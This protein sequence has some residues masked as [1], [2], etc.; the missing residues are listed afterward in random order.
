MSAAFKIRKG[1]SV[2]EWLERLP[3]KQSATLAELRSLIQ[4]NAPH[5]REKVKWS[6]P[7][8]EG[9][10]NVVYLAC[11]KNYATFGVCHGAHLDNPDGL[12]EGTGKDMRHVKVPSFEDVAKED[13]IAVLERAVEF[14]GMQ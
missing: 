6:H 1:E 4:K 2:E 3:S 10:G 14:D 8:Y 13:L 12:L 5:L 9:N 11:Q 7:W